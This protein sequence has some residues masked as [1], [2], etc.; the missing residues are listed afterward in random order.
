M[1][2]HPFL[3]S[4]LLL[5]SSA[6]LVKLSESLNTDSIDLAHMFR[7]IAIAAEIKMGGTSGAI[8]AIFINAVAEALESIDLDASPNKQS[9]SEIMSIALRKGLEDLFKFTTAREG[10][11]TLMDTLIP[12]VATFSRTNQDF[13]AA[14]EAA[15]QGCEKTKMMEALLGRASYVGKS[16]FEENGGIP[17][18]GALGVLSIL[19]GIKMALNSAVKREN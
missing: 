9:I 4:V 14:F 2:S 12:F 6:G 10:H 5:R 18:P 11:R 8:Y 17:D 16:R 15:Q 1:L 13:D 19:R 7:Q 3:P